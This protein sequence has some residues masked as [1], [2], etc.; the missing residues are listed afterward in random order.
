MW[1]RG[2]VILINKI[3][4]AGIFFFY[5]KDGI[6][7]KYVECLLEDMKKSM[8][9]LLIVCNGKL[10]AEDRKKLEVIANV[11][12]VRENKGYDVWAYKTGIEYLG[13]EK[14]QQYDE[15]VF[16]NFTMFGPLYPFAD[17]FQEMDTKE[18]DFW[19]ITAFNGADFDP[20]GTIK[21]KY[22]P[23]HIQSHFIAVRANLL[24]SFEFKKYWN[25][26]GEITCYE[27]AVGHHEAIFT[28]EFADKGY[29]WETYV[30][31]SDLKD[32][33]YC[34]IIMAP[35][36]LIK[37]RK[38][39]IIKRRSFFHSYEDYLSTTTGEV[40]VEAYEFIRD[41]LKYDV[42]MIWDNILRLQ[43]MSDIKKNM[44]FNYILPQEFVN[45]NISYAEDR[46]IALIIHIYFTELIEECIRY[47]DS[48]PKNADIVITTD[49]EIK[50]QAIKIKFKE[51]GYTKLGVKIIENRGRDVS[52]LLVGC[53]D[54]IMNY[55]Y[56][57]FAHDKKVKQ[58][59]PESK[60]ASFSYKCF[61]NIL[62]SKEYVQNIL[63]TFEKESRLGMLMPPPPNHAEYYSTLGLEWSWNLEETKKLAKKLKLNIP[64]SWDKEP[65]S[66]LGTM[67]WFR[68]KALKTLIEYNWQYNDFPEEPNKTDGTLL[69][70]IERIYS[71]VAQHEGYYVGW[72]MSDKYAR[73]EV[74]NLNYMLRKINQ[75]IFNIYGANTHYNLVET[76][77]A[78]MKLKTLMKVAI[79]NS[80][81]KYLPDSIVKQLKKIK[82]KL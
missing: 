16:F 72:A 78:Q 48:M 50:A 33:A 59:L 30:D 36:E 51:A 22:I 3:T 65:I 20:F 38:C 12:I 71:Y 61:E 60:G 77:T 54:I 64:M 24:R 43:D 49:T 8:E 37:N 79:K 27:E 70:A 29:K 56:V 66:P 1:K 2:K 75:P 15:V 19:G 68:P 67:F 23:E 58:L 17:M 6:V 28:K 52:S 47:A 26:M 39:P 74:T 31:T 13:W 4:R 53:K 76:L 40:S 44:H 62:A 80:L 21:Y 14:L 41:H 73:I 63:C 32:Y 18:L 34:P 55:D 57:C 10:N 25:E 69:H 9:Y 42:N 35:L 46:K 11:V 81:K 82:N 5:D 45:Q 7:D